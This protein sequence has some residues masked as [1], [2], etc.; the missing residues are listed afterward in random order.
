MT[1]RQRRHQLLALTALAWALGSG[2]AWSQTASASGAASAAAAPDEWK[3][4]TRQLDRQAV[5]ALLAKPQR[6][7]VLD[8]R[9]PDE[10]PEKGSFPAF[11]NIQSQ[12]IEKHLA[13]IPR[14]RVILTVSNHAHRAGA[15]GDV[16]RAKGFKVA[17]ATGSQDY[18]AQGGQAVVHIRPPVKAAAAGAAATAP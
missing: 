6:L 16:L 5:D 11:L 10:L 18:E 2:P 7:L 12:D 13:Y 8:V 15:V 9:R 3:Y 4:K 17:G 14:D 1:T